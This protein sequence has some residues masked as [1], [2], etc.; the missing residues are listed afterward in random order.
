MT[1]KQR[2]RLVNW[3]AGIGMVLGGAIGFGLVF[4][5]FKSNPDM[6]GWQF[7]VR[8]LLPPA[9]LGALPELIGFHLFSPA[10]PQCG[11]R[12]KRI[13]RR[14]IMWRCERCGFFENTGV[15]VDSGGS[16]QGRSTAR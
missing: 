16:S 15:F 10:C 8:F 12:L 9:L 2:A 6:P 5:G 7:F 1:L 14:S 13:G 11:H 3:T 4:I